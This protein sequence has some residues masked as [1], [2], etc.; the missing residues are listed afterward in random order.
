[1]PPPLLFSKGDIF[2]FLNNRQQRLENEVNGIDSRAI[3]Q[4]PEEEL[5][6]ALAARYKLAVPVLQEDNAYADYRE[7]DVDV[8][9]DPMRRFFFDEGGPAHVKGTEITFFLPFK[10]NGGLFD[11]RP[12][13]FTTNPPRGEIEGQEIR[14]TYQR[15]DTNAEAV[16]SDYQR[17]LGSIKQYL[18]WL[19]TSV[20]DFN[21]KIGFLVQTLINERKRKLAATSG[22]MQAIGLPVRRRVEVENQQ[23]R[24]STKA[25]SKSTASAKKWDVFISHATEDKDEIARPLA[26]ALQRRGA[27]VWYD[28]FSLNLGDSLRASID[29]GLAN[30]RYG[31]V[32]LSKHFFAKNWPIQEL[33]GLSTR[34]ANGNKVILPIWHAISFEEIRN[35]SPILADRLAAKSEVG[36]EALVEQIIGVLEQ[37]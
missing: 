31:V 25:I 8:S 11:I 18:G 30:S 1:M 35:S 36:I 10:G 20:L 32:I 15:T 9:R 23:P 16:K 2:G 12:Q 26:N 17:T 14:L 27:A 7:I 34:E 22:M 37:D 33:N 19:E 21:R 5:V 29:Y 3:Q 28:E 6:H 24:V 4:T 13:T